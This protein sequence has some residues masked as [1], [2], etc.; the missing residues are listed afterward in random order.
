MKTNH[1]GVSQLVHVKPLVILSK[2]LTLANQ[3]HCSASTL[4]QGFLE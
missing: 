4:L 2:Q 1:L 3:C